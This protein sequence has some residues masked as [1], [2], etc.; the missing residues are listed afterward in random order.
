MS[1][2]VVVGDLHGKHDIVEK[3][4]SKK[5]YLIVF[6]GDYL[7]SFDRSTVEQLH[8]IN[9]VLG[10]VNKQPERVTALRGNHE[11]SYLDRY[12][13]C[14]GYS[15]EL[16][17]QLQQSVNMEP[18][19]DYVWVGDWLI[20]HAGVSGR[21]LES[22]DQTTTE[23]L[24]KGKYCQIGRARGG[25]DAI[26]GLYWCDWWQ[27]FEPTDVPQIVGHSAYRPIDAPKGIVQKGNSY[28]IDCLDRVEEVLV[29][30]EEYNA[31]I[32]AIDD[33]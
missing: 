19:L 8:T 26:G 24:D 23:Y 14:S 20:S 22:L 10:A 27:E 7:D 2:L 29:L 18:L 3:V 32:W 4:L 17:A 21:L 11:M 6:I 25:R 28:N 33:L 13:Q 9:L 31:E 1:K 16:K 5:D 15:Y 12:M 30:N